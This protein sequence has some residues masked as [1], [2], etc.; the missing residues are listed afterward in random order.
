MDTEQAVARSEAERLVLA[1]E[2]SP[3]GN[4]LGALDYKASL[5]FWGAPSW[6]EIEAAEKQWWNDE[7][8][9]ETSRMRGSSS[10]F[11]KKIFTTEPWG[12]REQPWNVEYPRPSGADI[13]RC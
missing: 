2:F 11:R 10:P 8:P 5:Q 7:F 4:I 9:I 1:L 12:N 13:Q 3:E 6:V